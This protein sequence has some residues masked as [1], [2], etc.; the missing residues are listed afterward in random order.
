MPGL[1]GLEIFSIATPR[2][3][4]AHKSGVAT[5]PVAR[6]IPARLMAVTDCG[7]R[8]LEKRGKV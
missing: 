5:D 7:F 8:F 4:F 6:R 2:C 3:C 1:T